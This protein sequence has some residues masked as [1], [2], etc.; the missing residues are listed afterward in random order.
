MRSTQALVGLFAFVAIPNLAFAE[1]AEIDEFK[2]LWT[3]VRELVSKSEFREL[4]DMAQHFRNE[5]V[6]F[7]DGTWKLTHFYGAMTMPPG[8]HSSKNWEAF[9]SAIETWNHAMPDS[10]AAKIAKAQANR[11]YGTY[12]GPTRRNVFRSRYELA[13]GV[14][15]S[16]DSG[17]DPAILS[18][19][20]QVLTPLPIENKKEVVRLIFERGIA[21]YPDY[22]QTYIVYAL[23]L[24]PR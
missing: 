7:A 8:G 3:S 16:L 1:C 10:T 24:S 21:L 18:E 17:R 5:R 15:Q 6:R 11:G 12:M 22:L 2:E 13:L 19:A 20:I 23:F 9:F 4:E 14:L